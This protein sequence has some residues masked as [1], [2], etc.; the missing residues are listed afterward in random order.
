MVFRKL[1]AA[2]VNL[3]CGG[4]GFPDEQ[5]KAHIEVFIRKLLEQSLDALE[6]EGFDRGRARRRLS[7][8]LIPPYPDRKSPKSSR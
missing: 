3:R 6:Q 8:A 5:Y 4:R 1:R 7:L 2:V